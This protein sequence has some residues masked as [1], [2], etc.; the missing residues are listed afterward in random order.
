VLVSECWLEVAY[1]IRP[2]PRHQPLPDGIVFTELLHSRIVGYPESIQR[3]TT[4]PSRIQP[5]ICATH[6][7]RQPRILLRSA[8]PSPQ[9]STL[10]RSCSPVSPFPAGPESAILGLLVKQDDPPHYMEDHQ[11]KGL[12]KICIT[13]VV[14]KKGRCATVFWAIPACQLKP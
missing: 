13:Q 4:R 8:L 10:N 9:D 11:N 12:C 5:G 3:C 1:S 6:A 7:R 14:E 2:S